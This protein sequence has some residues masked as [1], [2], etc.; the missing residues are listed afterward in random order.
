LVEK[1]DGKEDDKVY[2]IFPADDSVREHSRFKPSK[3][4]ALVALNVPFSYHSVSANICAEGLTRKYF[5]SV[6]DIIYRKDQEDGENASVRDKEKGCNS[7]DNVWRA[8]FKVFDEERRQKFL[9]E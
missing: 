3:N 6:F 2:D 1:S 9:R 5:Y 8:K 7:V 4:R